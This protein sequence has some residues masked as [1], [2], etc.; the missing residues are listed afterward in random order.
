MSYWVPITLNGATT[1]LLN[2]NY[3]QMAGDY[4]N[5][6]QN[7]SALNVNNYAANGGITIGD[8]NIFNPS[9]LASAINDPAG[10]LNGPFSTFS[11]WIQTVAISC[12]TSCWTYPVVQT[13]TMPPDKWFELI[14]F[15]W[16]VNTASTGCAGT[17]VDQDGVVVTGYNA[18]PPISQSTGTGLNDITT[19][20]SYSGA[21]SG[22]IYV[23][24]SATGTPDHFEYAV[25]S[26]SYSA[27]IAITG[28]AQS[29]A[30]G[31]SITFAA[32]TGHT[33]GDTWT[34]T[35]YFQPNPAY[36]H[37]YPPTQT[38]NAT[39]YGYVNVGTGRLNG[40]DIYNMYPPG[41]MFLIQGLAGNGGAGCGSPSQNITFTMKGAFE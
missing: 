33:L 14:G 3:V 4:I 38:L 18:P 16:Y 9:G 8:G 6:L 40:A 1:V 23:K 29:L 26:G 7:A 27:P 22:Y 15:E 21:S 17:S 12:G 13:I 41:T 30:D 2:G 39:G 36:V 10:L 5:P 11:S 25:G 20:G 31:V 28:S 32:T 37:L 35:G 24:I 34:L 19:S